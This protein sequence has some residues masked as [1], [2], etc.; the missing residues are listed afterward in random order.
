MKRGTPVPITGSVLRWAIDQSGYSE[1]EVADRLKV[2][3]DTLHRWVAETERPLLGAFRG[4]AELLKRPTAIFFLPEPPIDSARRPDF[5]ASPGSRREPLPSELLAIRR[6]SRVQD[7]VAWVLEELSRPEVPLPGATPLEGREFL[8]V[9]V[10]AQR[11]AQNTS[12]A[13]RRWQD[14]LEAKGILVFQLSMGETA[15]RGFSLWNKRAPVIAINTA[16]NMAARIFTM[17]HEF[18]HLLAQADS[19]CVGM[20]VAPNADST[21]RGCEEFAADFLLPEPHL[22]AAISEYRAAH[23]MTVDFAMVRWLA[24]AF[25]VSLRAT[26]FT[27]VRRQYAKWDLYAAVDDAAKVDTDKGGGGGGGGESRPARRAREYGRRATEVLLGAADLGLLGSHD[28]TDFFE[29][30]PAEMAVLRGEKVG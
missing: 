11:K 10:A 29:I 2:D 26:A 24:N 14:A 25:K 8:D 23:G 27:L 22:S 15:C 16:Y 17:F 20:S 6:A 1:Q 30:R 5:R 13:F 4:V 12:R 28:I 3:V 18:A 21:E 9:S 7:A 19:V